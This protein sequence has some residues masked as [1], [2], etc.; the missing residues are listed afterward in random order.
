M[1][2]PLNHLLVLKL[3]NKL[4]PVTVSHKVF[5]TW[6]LVIQLRLDA[7]NYQY[8]FNCKA[9]E[10]LLGRCVPKLHCLEKF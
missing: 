2:S 6:N 10:I 7:P 5:E 3:E 8:I 9:W 1:S 4:D